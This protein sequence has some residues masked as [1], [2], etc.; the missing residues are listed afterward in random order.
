MFIKLNN[1]VLAEISN[2]TS[3]NC[4][5]EAYIEGCKFLEADE[6]VISLLEIM[7]DMARMGHI[8]DINYSKRFHIYQKMK[9]IARRKLFKPDFE[10]FCECF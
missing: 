8:S 4:H 1:K 9:Q 3:Y 5:T 2:L 6:L 7:S 10:K